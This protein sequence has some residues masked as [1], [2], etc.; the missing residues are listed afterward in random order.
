VGKNQSSLQVE[1]ETK[2]SG[3]AYREIFQ[4]DLI[5]KRAGRTRTL[6]GPTELGMDLSQGERYHFEVVDS[7]TAGSSRLLSFGIVGSEDTTIVWQNASYSPGVRLGEKRGLLCLGD[8]HV[9]FDNVYCGEI[10][11]RRVTVVGVGDRKRLHALRLFRNYPNPF[12]PVT[13]IEYSL[14]RRV[15]VRLQVFDV[16]GRLVRWLVRDRVQQPGF[17]RI[18]WDGRND[19]GRE[20]ASGVY[21]LSLSVEGERRSAKLVVVK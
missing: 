14:P 12:N 13:V 21:F 4:A 3:I 15:P 19:S 16:S 1:E 8:S 7:A 11:A 10:G 6:L 9:H 18:Q 5:R 20:V 17:H 2:S